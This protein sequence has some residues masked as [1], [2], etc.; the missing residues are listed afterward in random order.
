MVLVGLRWPSASRFSA[1]TSSSVSGSMSFSKT[2]RGIFIL[3]MS[4][5]RRRLA[6]AGLTSILI[7]AFNGFSH[8]PSGTSTIGPT[9]GVI[10]GSDGIFGA[11]AFSLV[12]FMTV[13]PRSA[14]ERTSA[15]GSKRHGSQRC[16]LAWRLHHTA[17][18]NVFENERVKYQAHRSHVACS[19]PGK[20][21]ETSRRREMVAVSHECATLTKRP[22]ARA[23]AAFMEARMVMAKRW[24]HAAE[25]RDDVLSDVDACAATEC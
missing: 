11:A 19:G 3:I 16:K 24:R 1:D 4:S 15:C 22:G 23:K 14:I 13:E 20:A 7:A 18:S 12:I 8:Q 6:V 5:L 2:A 9:G 25:P 10:F 17:S 21:T